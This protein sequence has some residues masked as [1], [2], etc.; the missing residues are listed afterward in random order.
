MGHERFSGSKGD[1]STG[2]F[3]W[4]RTLLVFAFI[5]AVVVL[6]GIPVVSVVASLIAAWGS[7]FKS[8]ES[9]F[10]G[11]AIGLFVAAFLI[12]FWVLSADWTQIALWGPVVLFWFA[13]YFL[14][15]GT[16]AGLF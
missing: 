7:F 8:L 10:L 12:V 15:L 16:A 1:R 4:P 6:C 11:L 2:V 13:T 5:V 3:P 14:G 9:F